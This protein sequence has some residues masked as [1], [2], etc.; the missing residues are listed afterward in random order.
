MKLGVAVILIYMVGSSLWMPA[1]LLKNHLTTL[2]T[3]WN[4]GAV[5]CTVVVGFFVFHEHVTAVQWVGVGLAFVSC[6]LLSL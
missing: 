4:I 5:I 2:G 6:V 1:I 3:L